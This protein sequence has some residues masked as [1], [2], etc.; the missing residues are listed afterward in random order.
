MAIA[1]VQ[2]YLESAL[3]LAVNNKS[4]TDV[5]LRLPE[6]LR[7]LTGIKV[8]NFWIETA[9]SAFWDG[10]GG[11]PTSVPISTN[12]GG[13][14]GGLFLVYFSHPVEITHVNGIATGSSSRNASFYCIYRDRAGDMSS[15]AAGIASWLSF[16]NSLSTSS[17]YTA[18][19]GGAG[20]GADVEYY[21]LEVEFE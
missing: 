19:V 21:A 12:M 13:A 18:R 7:K 4:G 1:V 16:A 9:T 14:V 6:D 2:K 20:Q 10:S 11:S 3:S 15:Q 5:F 17:N 8:K